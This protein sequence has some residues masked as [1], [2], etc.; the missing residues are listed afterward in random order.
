MQHVQQIKMALQIAGVTSQES[1]FVVNGDDDTDGMQID[2]LIDRSDNV[3]DICEMK[4]TK[5]PYEM[6][7]TEDAKIQNRRSRFI[8]ESGTDKAIHLVLVSAAG[9][10]RNS[11][12][13]E[14]QSVITAESLFDA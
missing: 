1:S 9:V 8:E 7:A 6:D 3:I 2:L 14:F 10:K 5:E 11:Y 4:F 13:D 12:S